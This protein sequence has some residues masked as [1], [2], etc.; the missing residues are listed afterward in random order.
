M[1]CYYEVLGVE[2][3]ATQDEIKKAHR[4]GAL[5]WHPDKNKD[6]PDESHKNMQIIQEAYDTL[7]DLQERAFYDKHRVQILGGGSDYKDDSVNVMTFFRASCYSGFNDDPQGFYCVYSDLFNSISEEDRKHCDGPYEEPPVF[8][9]SLSDWDLVR[10]FYGWWQSYCT[11]KSYCWLDELYDVRQ[12]NGRRVLRAMEKE[13]KKVM[14][15]AKKERNEEIRALVLHVKRRDPRCIAQKEKQRIETEEKTVADKARREEA[16]RK[17]QEE[18]EMLAEQAKEDNAEMDEQVDTLLEQYSDSEEDDD[19][20]YCPLCKKLFKSDKMMKQHEKSKKHKERLAELKAEFGDELQEAGLVKEDPVIEELEVH[21]SKKKSKKKK[22]NKRQQDTNMYNLDS[23]QDDLEV[24]KDLVEGVE[25]LEIK[26]KNNE[27]EDDQ[28][29][30]G[31]ASA[32]ASPVP[33]LI[34]TLTSPH[35]APPATP[36]SP[37]E[38]YEIIST[39][40]AGAEEGDIGPTAA[41]CNMCNAEFSSKSKLFAHLKETGHAIRPEFAKAAQ[42]A[43]NPKKEKKGKGNKKLRN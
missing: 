26:D 9:D 29:N 40:K 33:D 17:R 20:F 35:P 27:K 25:E 10:E 43:A 34:E 38:E 4:K 42:K 32:E 28:Q 22:K 19:P 37:E 13:N 18:I 8:G 2:K 7:S 41:K 3:T 1:K 36:L 31:E 5:R 11:K 14:D 15:D 30:E 16:R 39:E 24:V 21:A 12:A 23:D 6:N